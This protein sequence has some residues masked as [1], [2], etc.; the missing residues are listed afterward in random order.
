LLNF[1]LKRDHGFVSSA[2]RVYDDGQ[3]AS[4]MGIEIT[5]RLSGARS[6]GT[7]EAGGQRPRSKHGEAVLMAANAAQSA[8]TT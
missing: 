6:G 1:N 3:L 2:R 4:P 5:R 8:G 7:A